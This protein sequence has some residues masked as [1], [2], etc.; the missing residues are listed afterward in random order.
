MASLYIYLSKPSY[1]LPTS[2][3]YWLCLH[4]ANWSGISFFNGPRISKIRNCIHLAQV[5]TY[6]RPS[7]FVGRRNPQTAA[8]WN[9][10]LDRSLA[11]KYI[12]TQA[13]V[14]RAS[15]HSS[16]LRYFRLHLT[17]K[18]VQFFFFFSKRGDLFLSLF[19]CVTF[20]NNIERFVSVTMATFHIRTARWCLVVARSLV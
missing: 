3:P 4:L 10:S 1:P 19:L 11:V 16:S 2:M 17:C 14:D 20:L 8:G 18:W 15:K 6:C 5:C 13:A 9:R 7:K 12:N